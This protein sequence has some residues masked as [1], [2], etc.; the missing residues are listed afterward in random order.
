MQPLNFAPKIDETA[1]PSK[2]VLV[3]YTTRCGGCGAVSDQSYFLAHY[4]VKGQLKDKNGTC[5]RACAA[6][7]FNLPV[8]RVRGHDKAIPFCHVCPT[9]ELTHL[10]LPPAASRLSPPTREA[11]VAAHKP[12]K[13]AARPNVLDLA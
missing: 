1:I 10:P 7:T 13:P 2:Y 6:P 5:R 11:V 12:A 4:E 9:I 8:E 3:T